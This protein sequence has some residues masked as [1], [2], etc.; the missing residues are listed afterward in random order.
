MVLLFMLA[1]A[2]KNTDRSIPS[3]YCHTEPLTEHIKDYVYSLLDMTQH[4]MSLLSM[5]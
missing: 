2:E 3:Y 4:T 1:L 5:A